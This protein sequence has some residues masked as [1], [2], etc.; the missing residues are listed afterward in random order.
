MHD[1][2]ICFAYLG[3]ARTTVGNSVG[4]EICM[5]LRRIRR[6]KAPCSTCRTWLRR[7]PSTLKWIL[8]DWNDD[9]CRKLL[10]VYRAALPTTVAY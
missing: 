4:A 6:S 10:K 1:E 5:S 3:D 2:W 9:S 8:H 7:R